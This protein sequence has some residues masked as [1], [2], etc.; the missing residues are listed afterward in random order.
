MFTHLKNTIALAAIL[1]M[2][3]SLC[4]KGAVQDTVKT[5]V[6]ITSIHNIDFKQKEYTIDLWLWLRYKNRKFDFAQNLEIPMA[7]NVTRSYLTSDTTAD[8]SIYMLMKLQCVMKDEWKVDN[9]PFD[10]QNLRFSIEN[11]QFDSS[12][13]LFIADTAGQHFDKKFTLRKWSIDSILITTGNRVYETAFG[14]AAAQTP[15][16]VYSNYR[17]KM[18][19]TRNAMGIFWKLFLG[20]YLSFLIAYMCFYIHIDSIDSRFSLAVGAL[21]A[22]VGNKYIV[23]SSLPESST[24]TLVDTLHGITLFFI[25]IIMMSNAYVLKLSKQG[26]ERGIIHFDKLCARAMLAAY[27][28]LNVWFIYMACCKQ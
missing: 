20:M 25:L 7:K 19:V 1:V 17:V 22:V 15:K 23:D 4:A 3:C 24:F 8:S 28:L 5:G 16:S 11:S 2:H 21:F 10:R 9:F 6:Y 13:L 12:T 27:V 26:N 18:V 14:D